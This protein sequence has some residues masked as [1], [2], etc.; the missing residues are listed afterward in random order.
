MSPPPLSQ[1][2]YALHSSSYASQWNC[3]GA[4]SGW[5]D[6]I[7][8]WYLYRTYS[9]PQLSANRYRED[10]MKI[11][12]DGKLDCGCC[13]HKFHVVF[14]WF[15][16]SQH[17]FYQGVDWGE[18]RDVYIH[19]HQ[20]PPIWRYRVKTVWNS[21]RQQAKHQ[22]VYHHG[23]IHETCLPPGYV[24]PKWKHYFY[25]GVDWD[26]RPPTRWIGR[27]GD[28]GSGRRQHEIYVDNNHSRIA[29]DLRLAD[30][31]VDEMGNMIGIVDDVGS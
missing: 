13:W 6:C 11:C 3:Q 29:L 19:N 31:T 2:A 14:A 17:Y 22:S 5:V 25:Q 7:C 12:I 26:I 21:Y 27:I 18:G 8:S 10:H 24:L 28:V 30:D 23:E 9:V 1:F 4:N 15:M 20:R 16:P